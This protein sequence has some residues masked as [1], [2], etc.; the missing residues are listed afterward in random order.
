MNKHKV[1]NAITQSII[2]KVPTNENVIPIFTI[3]LTHIYRSIREENTIAVINI[4][5]RL[6]L[7]AKKV[8]QGNTI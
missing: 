2:I 5:C 8:E 7:D 4:R 1:L 3:S 6:K